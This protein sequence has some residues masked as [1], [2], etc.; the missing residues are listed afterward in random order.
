MSETIVEA[1]TI[2]LL[3]AVGRD[4]I[5][6]TDIVQWRGFSDKIQNIVCKWYL[7]KKA[8]AGGS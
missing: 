1:T 4:K 5:K 7:L 6:N 2:N 8:K 3:W